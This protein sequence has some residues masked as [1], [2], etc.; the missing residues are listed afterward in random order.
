MGN[1]CQKP[2]FWVKNN[3]HIQNTFFKLGFEFKEVTN[4]YI[5]QNHP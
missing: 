1:R 2:R 4:S 3:G 5:F